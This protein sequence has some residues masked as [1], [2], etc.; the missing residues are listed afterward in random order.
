V[1]FRPMPL[2]AYQWFSCKPSLYCA[3][4][5]QGLTSELQTKNGDPWLPVTLLIRADELCI[6]QYVAPHR[7]LDLRFRRVF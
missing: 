2:L 7:S 3:I 5:D 4:K 1:I 6:G